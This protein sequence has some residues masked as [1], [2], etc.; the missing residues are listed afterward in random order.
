MCTNHRS[1]TQNCMH[2]CDSVMVMVRMLWLMML[3]MLMMIDSASG[4]G[5]PAAASDLE[6]GGQMSSSEQFLLQPFFAM[7]TVI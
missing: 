1:N 2:N 7:L 5:A 4:G 3:V 6:C